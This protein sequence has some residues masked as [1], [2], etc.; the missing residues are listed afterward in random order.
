MT[1]PTRDISL[2]QNGQDNRGTPSCV[3][4]LS[5][6]FTWSEQRDGPRNKKSIRTAYTLLHTTL[7]QNLAPNKMLLAF[8]ALARSRY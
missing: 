6:Q 7:A 8:K 4:P 2:V 5:S 3:V 1:F